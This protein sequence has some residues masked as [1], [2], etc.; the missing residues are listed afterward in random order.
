MPEQI[1]IV[2]GFYDQE[3]LNQ[4]LAGV[5]CK[6]VQLY[7]DVDNPAIYRLGVVLYTTVGEDE[8]A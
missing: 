2:L 4:L 6:R 3:K 7:P 1:A 5:E 8:L